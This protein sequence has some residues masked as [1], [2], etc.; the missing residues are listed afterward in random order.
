MFH[1]RDPTIDYKPIYNSGL[2]L[3]TTVSSPK[4]NRRSATV[5]LYGIRRYR[6]QVMGESHHPIEKLMK[7]LQEKKVIQREM[8]HVLIPFQ[9]FYH[10]DDGYFYTASDHVLLSLAHLRTGTKEYPAMIEPDIIW[11]IV[12]QVSFKNPFLG[13]TDLGQVLAGLDCLTTQGLEHS[14]LEPKN[15]LITHDGVVKI[16]RL[17]RP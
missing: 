7:R 11:S 8:Q 3:M 5:G 6:A 2:D 4:G 17:P 9:A 15:I 16:G 13:M 12:Q 14:N 1:S 10:A